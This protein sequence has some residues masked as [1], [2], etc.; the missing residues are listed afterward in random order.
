MGKEGDL[1]RLGKP[2]SLIPAPHDAQAVAPTG[3]LTDHTMK[4]TTP[5]PQSNPKVCDH[6]SGIAPKILGSK[7]LSGEERKQKCSG[8][9]PEASSDLQ[10]LPKPLKN[11]PH[12]IWG[13]SHNASYPDSYP[14]LTAIQRKQLNDFV[15]KCP[16]DYGGNILEH[17]IQNW[18]E[19]RLCAKKYEAAFALPL[20]PTVGF[21]L[22]FIASAVRQWMDDN[23]L[24]YADG[25]LHVDLSTEP[26][27]VAAMEMTSIVKDV[28]VPANNK[29]ATLKEVYEILFDT[30]G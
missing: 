1:T 5:I 8:Q 20:K 12:V 17:V 29:A 23:E 18:S 11:P 26:N 28:P 24:V 21:L 27:P 22:K 4:P 19:F 30:A 6:P 9:I 2:S 13:D 25:I 10:G 7:K 14:A 15:S 3:T 16:T